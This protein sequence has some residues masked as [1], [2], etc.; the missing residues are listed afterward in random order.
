MRLHSDGGDFV[1]LL[2]V[3][4]D[5]YDVLLTISVSRAGFSA[6]ADTWISADAWHAFAQQLSVLEERRQ[7]DAR[8][9]SISPG[10]LLLVVKSVDRA[11][12]LGVEGR[13]GTQTYDAE[14]TMQFSVFGF[15]PSQLAAFAREARD[16]SGAVAATRSST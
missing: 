8:V 13:V 9:E 1:E 3:D 12:H 4:G 10:E 2:R 14:V 7:G 11:G 15:D 5:A 16:I 6:T